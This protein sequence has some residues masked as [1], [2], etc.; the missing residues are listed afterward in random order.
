[1]SP[2][3]LRFLALASVVLPIGVGCLHLGAPSRPLAGSPLGGMC[4][5]VPD[6]DTA[7]G[8]PGWTP[9][10]AVNH[11]G[12]AL[13]TPRCLPPPAPSDVLDATLRDILGQFES[14]CLGV[15]DEVDL[16]APEAAPTC[17]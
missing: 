6:M 15:A 17:S 13:D 10:R 1:M 16:G 4:R 9:R 3:V 14:R 7:E 8:G 11:F 2:L 12:T 5:V